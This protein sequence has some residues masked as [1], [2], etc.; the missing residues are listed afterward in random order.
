MAMLEMSRRKLNRSV[1]RLFFV[2]S[3]GTYDDRRSYRASSGMTIN[4]TQ[5]IVA[6][7]RSGDFNF[8]KPKRTVKGI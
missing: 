8:L 6:A 3:R 2:L 4:S 5:K 1:L 7:A